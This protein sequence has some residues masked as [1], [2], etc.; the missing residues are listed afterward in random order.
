MFSPER[1][2]QTV[3]EMT[4]RV[5]LTTTQQ[6]ELRRIL[7]EAARGAENI[8]TATEPRTTQRHQ[9]MRGL[10]HGADDRIWALLSCEQKDLYR[11][12]KR[13]RRMMHMQQRRGQGRGH[14]G[15]MGMGMGR[16]ASGP[17][18]SNR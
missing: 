7:E 6:A 2:T 1:I 16:G 5:Q 13:D 4:E 14:H 11:L 15:G 12:Y 3:E 10:R 8:R 17:P 9:A 18:P